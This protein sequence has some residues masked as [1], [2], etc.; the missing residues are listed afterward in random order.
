MHHKTIVEE[1]QKFIAKAIDEISSS[2]LFLVLSGYQGYYRVTFQVF[3]WWIGTLYKIAV[4]QEMAHYVSWFIETKSDLQTR[5][6]L[7]LRD[8]SSRPSIRAWRKKF[9]QTGTVFDKGRSGRPRTSEGNIDRVLMCFVQLMPIQR[10]IKRGKNKLQY[11]RL[12]L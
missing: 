2:G 10:C 5:E 12:I 3:C 9:M 8:P 11:I 1:F 4:L 7:E 6:T